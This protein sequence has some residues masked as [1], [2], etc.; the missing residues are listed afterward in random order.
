MTGLCCS[1]WNKVFKS[2]FLKGLESQ[3]IYYFYVLVSF[4]YKSEVKINIIWS[5][6]CHSDSLLP[7]RYQGDAE[8]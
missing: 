1:T 5:T 2:R 4:F 7:G 3:L 6:G 8:V